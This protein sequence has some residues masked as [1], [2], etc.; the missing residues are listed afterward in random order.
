LRLILL[1]NSRQHDGMLA[2]LVVFL[3]LIG[4]FLLALVDAR[5]KKLRYIR[6][7]NDIEFARTNPLFFEKLPASDQLLAA[8]S[9]YTRLI[10]A[11]MDH[12]IKL[13]RG[14]MVPV[15]MFDPSSLTSPITEPAPIALRRA[16]FSKGKART[17]D[18]RSEFSGRGPASQ[19]AGRAATQWFRH[20]A[21]LVGRS[22][23]R[24]SG[25]A[26]AREI[27]DS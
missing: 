20:R 11:V 19:P 23:P 10:N 8:S 4:Y 15:R 6:T 17:R 2:T 13:S 24:R 5:D 16:N 22:H 21:G 27:A 12:A 26:G 14:Q 18:R 25:Q 7:R 9:T 3:R 1:L